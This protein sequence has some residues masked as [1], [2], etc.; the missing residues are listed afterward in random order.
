MSNKLAQVVRASRYPWASGHMATNAKRNATTGSR[1]IKEPAENKREQI[2][3]RGEQKEYLSR[4]VIAGPLKPALLG[5]QINYGVAH[6]EN[7]DSGANQAQRRHHQPKGWQ[8]RRCGK[9]VS[10]KVVGPIPC[11][12]R[13][14]LYN[15]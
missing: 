9:E 8:R 14:L 5:E 11:G 1:Y 2:G 13:T 7:Q 15:Q 12:M 10:R 3:G 6:F 4:A